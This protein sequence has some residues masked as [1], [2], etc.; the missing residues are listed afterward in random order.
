MAE[1]RTPDQMVADVVITAG[2]A[3]A[4]APALRPG[5]RAQATGPEGASIDPSR[6]PGPHFRTRPRSVW[7]DRARATST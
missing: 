3:R 2:L 7:L 1:P 4:Q 6:L 5:G